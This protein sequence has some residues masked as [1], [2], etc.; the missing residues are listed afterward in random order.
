[1]S[2][3]GAK[4]GKTTVLGGKGP[5]SL[6]EGRLSRRWKKE[7]ES[8]IKKTGG[9]HR[10]EKLYEK[11]SWEVTPGHPRTFLLFPGKKK[12]RKK[13]LPRAKRASVLYRSLKGGDRYGKRKLPVTTNDRAF[14]DTGKRPDK[15]GGGKRKARWPGAPS[16]KN[17]S[18][19]LRKREP[20]G[21]SKRGTLRHCFW[22]KTM[23]RGKRRAPPKKVPGKGEIRLG[24]QKVTDDDFEVCRYPAFETTRGEYPLTPTFR[25]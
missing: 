19:G 24:K 5:A 3:E 9:K 23:S 13:N 11:K 6:E 14:T 21:N 18:F 25:T 8:N 12:L 10:P 20:Q 22:G 7:R 1:M 15:L 2:G 4:G 17:V 16:M